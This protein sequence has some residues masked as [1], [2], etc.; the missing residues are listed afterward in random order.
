[1]SDDFKSGMH[2]VEDFCFKVVGAK[3]FCELMEEESCVGVG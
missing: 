1:V 3:D 2:S